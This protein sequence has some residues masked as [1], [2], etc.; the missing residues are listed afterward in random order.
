[1]CIVTGAVQA[2]AR[3]VVQDEAVFSLQ[4][5]DTRAAAPLARLAGHTDEVNCVDMRGGLLVSGGCDAVVRLWDWRAGQCVA[6]LAGHGGKVAQ[7]RYYCH[8]IVTIFHPP[9]VVSVV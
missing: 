6:Q 5:W 1:M 7:C 3:L 2:G 4:V 8:Y 9:G